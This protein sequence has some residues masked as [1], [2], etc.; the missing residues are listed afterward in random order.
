MQIAEGVE[1]IRVHWVRGPLPKGVRWRNAVSDPPCSGAQHA[2]LLRGDKMSTLF[3]PYSMQGYLVPNDCSEVTLAD[4]DVEFR[5]EYV[6]D[7]ANRKWAQYQG[8]G[9]QRDYDTCALVMRRM[10]WEVPAQVM[11]G[12]QEDTRKKG[13]KD[14]ATTLIKPVK[15]KGKRGNFLAWFLD[16]EGSRSIREAMAEFSMTRS[17]VL[18]YLHMLRKDH[19]IGYELVGDM[20][21]LQLPEGCTD[22]FNETQP[23]PKAEEKSADDDFDWLD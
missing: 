2:F 19:G 1:W 23:E 3:C 18:S 11:A 8:W 9:Q 21:T 17:N 22:P 5:P 4:L 6:A 13:G 20:A 15:R 12:G 14:V 7:L 16:N 10:G